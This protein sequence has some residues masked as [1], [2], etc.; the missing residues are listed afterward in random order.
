MLVPGDLVWAASTAA[1]AEWKAAMAPLYTAGIPVYPL[2]GNHERNNPAAFISAFGEDI[3]DNGPPGEINRTYAI[4]HGNVLILMLD[5]YVTLHRV[6]QPW[7]DSILTTNILPHVFAV[8]HEPAF[9]VRHSGILDLYPQERDAFWRSLEFGAAAAYFCGHDHFY[10]HA[11]IDNGDGDPSTDIHQYIVGTAGAPL[12]DDGASD[13]DNGPWSPQRIL[14]EKQYGYV[15]V[16]INGM[17][18]VIT[19]KRRSAPG[20]YSAGADIHTRTARMQRPLLSIR[21]TADQISLHAGR[22]TP[23]THNTV[24]RARALGSTWV[25]VDMF[26]ASSNCWERSYPLQSSQQFYKLHSL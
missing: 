20:V 19:W 8:G 3:P 11:R 25:M 5:N 14:H 13:G 4:T 16:E 17:N 15:S 10:D 1:F 24:H 18:A 12:Y 22:L 9:K 21:R 6:N 26:K 7:I 23:G 2:M